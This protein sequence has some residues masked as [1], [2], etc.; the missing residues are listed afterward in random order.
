MFSSVLAS[1][2]VRPPVRGS[3][4]RHSAHLSDSPSSH[5]ASST[6]AAICSPEWL[7]SCGSC[8]L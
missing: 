2:S 3:P 1:W 5:R 8:W 4:R 7:E 6:P